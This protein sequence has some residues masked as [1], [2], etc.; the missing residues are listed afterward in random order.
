MVVDLSVYSWFVQVIESYELS[1]TRYM[2]YSDL[3]I[4]LLVLSSC[5]RVSVPKF[6]RRFGLLFLRLERHIHPRKVTFSKRFHP[7]L[8]FPEPM[9]QNAVGLQNQNASVTEQWLEILR[10]HASSSAIIR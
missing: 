6:L 4:R 8:C 3:S 2:P 1:S 5:M 9:L 7:I 10:M